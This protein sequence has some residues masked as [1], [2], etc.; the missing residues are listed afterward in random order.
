MLI[1]AKLKVLLVVLLLCFTPTLFADQIRVAVASNFAGVMKVLAEAFKTDTGH[2]IVLIVGS[3]GKLYAQIENGAPYDLFF[4]ADA[5]RPE[6]LEKKGRSV[7]GSRFT[8]AVGQVVLWS[9]DSELIGPDG[10]VLGRGQYRFLAVANPKLAP[11]GRAAQEF[12]QSRGLWQKLQP[13]IVRGENI[14]QAYQFVRSGN[15]QLG[16]VAYAQV[17]HPQGEVTGSH[18]L[19]PQ[20]LYTPI[21]Q[22]AVMLKESSIARAFMRYIKSK[23]VTEML[24][25]NGYLTPEV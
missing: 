22:Q 2:R 17:K 11:Y 1:K 5:K 14:G 13:K 18:W 10:A 9:P 25:Q 16:F 3:T 19:V 4:S 20:R 23:K 7:R 6:L 24:H 12:L 21:L 8:Y 15:A